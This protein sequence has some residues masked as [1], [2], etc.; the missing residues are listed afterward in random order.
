V[1]VEPEDLDALRSHLAYAVDDS[2][3]RVIS[4]EGRR[5]AGA[6]NTGMRAAETEFV[7][8]LLGDD[9]WAPH[10]VAVLQASIRV[11]PEVDLFHS[12]R[13]IVDDEGRPIGREF[14]PP[15]TVS[16]DEFVWKSPVKHLLCWRRRK[17]LGFGGL[18]EALTTAGP[19]DY[20]FPW[21]MLEQGAVFRAVPDCLYVYRD[22]RV[23]FR[24]TTHLPRS[25]HLH[26]LRYILT[27]HGVAPGL[28]EQRLRSAKR[29]FLRQ[30]L[31]RNGFHRWLKQLF[32]HDPA[33]TWRLD[34]DK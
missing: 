25:I 23:A 33:S 1:V 2:R 28:I 12:G 9:L 20:D 10:A 3:V 24:N 11:H 19:D 31:Y 8:I 7:A 16:L 34:Y 4:N 14:H 18:D 22:H 17:A 6:F 30:C 5:H 13:R 32:G 26:D 27:K 21:T 15:D 29:G